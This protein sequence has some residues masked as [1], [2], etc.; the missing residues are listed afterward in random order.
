VEDLVYGEVHRKEGDEWCQQ[1]DGEVHPV[2]V[3][4]RNQN[5][6]QKWMLDQAARCFNFEPT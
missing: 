6:D 1:V 5:V 4:L 3:D 2:D